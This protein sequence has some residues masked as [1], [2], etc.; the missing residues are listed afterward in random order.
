[1]GFWNPHWLP[2]GAAFVDWDALAG[3]LGLRGPVDPPARSR[4]RLWFVTGFVAFF[5]LQA[6]WLNERLHAYPFSRFA[7]F[8]VVRAKRPYSVHQTYE[9]PGGHLEALGTGAPSVDAWLAG[10]GTYR[11]LWRERDP[12]A[13]RQTLANVLA[14]ARDA[15]PGATFTGTRMWLS[16]F[17]APA[18]PAPARLDRSDIA[19]L[20]ELDGG[21]FHSAIGTLLPDG[22]TWI[23]PPSAPELTGMQLFEI[24][25]DLPVPVLVP[26]QPTPTGFVLAAPLRGDP[27]YL[28]GRTA[29]QGQPWLLAFRGRRGY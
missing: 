9:M 14:E 12:D 8:A 22:R 10:R 27:I 11:W 23:A 21:A 13:L 5:A 4:R 29:G 24:R 20:G 3:H 18:Y 17:Q 1:M 19:V 7:L 16:I 6:L 25:D 26:A 28:I 2:L 15:W